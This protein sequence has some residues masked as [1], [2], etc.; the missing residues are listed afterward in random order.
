MEGRE[1]VHPTIFSVARQLLLDQCLGHLDDVIR[2]QSLFGVR[3][4]SPRSFLPRLQCRSG[5]R[6]AR[7]PAVAPRDHPGGEPELRA[8]AEL[9]A[10]G[11][12]LAGAG[13]EAATEG[14]PGRNRVPKKS[15]GLYIQC[16]YQ[17]IFKHY[18]VSIRHT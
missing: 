5:L 13:E 6:W 1:A 12:G 18:V 14:E 2:C 15:S 9:A 17:D 10:F 8:A 7:Q 11:R 4:V 16:Q 3:T